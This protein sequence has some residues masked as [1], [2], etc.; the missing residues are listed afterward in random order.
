[1]P[2]GVAAAA[3]PAVMSVAKGAGENGGA[4]YEVG[5]GG[6]AADYRQEAAQY[7]KDAFQILPDL[8]VLPYGH[9]AAQP[10]IAFQN[11]DPWLGQV[12]ELNEMSPELAAQQKA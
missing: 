12:Y 2:W 11:Y 9:Y 3:I 10:D 1:M 6:S 5:N 4:D 8:Q 7:M